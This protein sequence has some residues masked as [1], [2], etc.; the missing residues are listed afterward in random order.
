MNSGANS[1]TNT[2][3]P[4]ST[5]H[6]FVANSKP[7]QEATAKQQLENQGYTVYLPFLK[8]SKHIRGRWQEKIE[9]LFPG[10]LF[11]KLDLAKD[12]LAPIRST[13]G[14]KGLIRFGDNLAPLPD[15][16]IEYVQSRELEYLSEKPEPAKRFQKG[17]SLNIVGGPFDGLEAVFQMSNS[18][19]R[20]LVLLSILGG[21]KTVSIDVNNITPAEQT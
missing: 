21:Q 9:V 18:T 6:W 2:S 20:V 8:R 11:L 19:D 7:R 12:N 3:E 14:M 15:E 13:R 1:Q 17:D 10:Y 4:Q 5:R 16:V